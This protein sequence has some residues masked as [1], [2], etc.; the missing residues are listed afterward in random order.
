MFIQVFI[1]NALLV[2]LPDA[3]LAGTTKRGKERAKWKLAFVCSLH[4][5]YGINTRMRGCVHLPSH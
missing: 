4:S 5:E 2:R 3:E 1:Q